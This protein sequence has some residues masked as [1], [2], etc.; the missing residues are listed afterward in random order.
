MDDTAIYYLSSSHFP[1]APATLDWQLCGLDSK[2]WESPEN[3]GQPIQAPSDGRFVSSQ[4]TP[5]TIKVLA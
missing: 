2:F 1:D 4:P 5:R 3:H